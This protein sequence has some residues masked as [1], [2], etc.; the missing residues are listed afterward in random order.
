M[1]VLAT[2]IRTLR[3]FDL[4]QAGDRVLA[5]VS[6]GADS[7]ALVHLLRRCESVPCELAVA[8]LDHGQRGADGT[9]DA[10][11]VRGLAAELEVPFFT[12]RLPAAAPRAEEELR[13]E[14]L[15]FL[16]GAVRRWN[17]AAVAVGHQRDDQT[18]TLLLNLLRGAGRHGLGGLPAVSRLEVAT[19][20]LIRPLI[21]LP[22]V[23]LRAWLTARE[24]P[25]REDASNNDPRY[26]RN[27][28]RRELLP[29][30][31]D[32]RPGAAA[33]IARAAGLLRDDED[34][35]LDLAAADE[36]G[37]TIA[38]GVAHLDAVALC[39]LPRPLA[40]R[41][42]RRAAARVAGS[43][44]RDPLAGGADLP[45]GRAPWAPGAEQVDAVLDR[46][47][48]RRPGQVDLGRGWV[49]RLRRNILELARVA[50]GDRHA[51][52]PKRPETRSESGT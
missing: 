42:L 49:A 6:G 39:A 22:R 18:E 40:R 34:L 36:A 11:V 9:A 31:E 12:D 4:F 23:E 30:L 51:R 2:F 33:T 35:L 38:D 24:L 17:A 32:L 41:L 25:W 45:P 46:I 16:A 43:I 47:R 44:A 19:A 10:E 37:L 27:R 26:L 1:D 20:R 50:T 48:D 7:V 52:P 21:A 5:A 3:H 8:H 14:R 28:V 29:L 13:G 15:R